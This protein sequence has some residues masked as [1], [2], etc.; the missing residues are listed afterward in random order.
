[1]TPRYTLYDIADLR[2]RFNLTAGLPKGIRSHYVP[3]ANAA[4]RGL[5]IT[6]E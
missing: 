3:V 2:D 5:I 1:M 6:K 4:G